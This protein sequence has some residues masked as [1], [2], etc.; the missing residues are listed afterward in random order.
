MRIT[1]TN[2][3]VALFSFALLGLGCS[4]SADGT[5]DGAGA[6]AAGAT[7]GGTGGTSGAA[8]AGVSGAGA[9]TGGGGAATGGA[10]TGG[11]PSGGTGGTTTGGTAG[12]GG[13]AGM[14]PTSG[15][16]ASSFPAS[17]TYTMEIQAKTREWVI[18]VPDGY[19]PATPTILVFVYHGFGGTAAMTAGSGRFG[20]F[21]LSTVVNGAAILV[22]PQG[23]PSTDGGDDFAW[24]NENAEDTEF[25]R[26][27]IERFSSEYCIDAN[28]IFVTGM[29]YGG[30]ASNDIGCDVGDLV[31]AIAP[32]AGAGPGFGQ[33]GG[34]GPTCMGQVAALMIHGETDETVPFTSG[35]E[36][37]DHWLA[38]NGCGDQAAPVE[39]A[40]CAAYE[41]CECVEYS[42]CQADHPVQFCSHPD[43]HIIPN[44]SAQTIWNFFQRF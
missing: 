27:M 10:A 43:G 33:F 32:I 39:N 11:S 15:C 24:R 19:D 38:A 37:R 13:G 9:S 17:G 42:G 44:F 8:G 3:A 6:G 21:G 14:T 40:A 1:I 23:L 29:S 31:R 35:E 20:Y 5:G 2:G 28:R 25:A 41:G 12:S 22:A 18:T 4:E 34:G 7:T 36:S 30:V 26:R 16:N